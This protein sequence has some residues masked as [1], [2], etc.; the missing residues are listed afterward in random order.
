MCW[1]RNK[2]RQTDEGIK[3]K[4]SEGVD[5]KKK[6]GEREIEHKSSDES[7]K[8]AVRDKAEVW[9]SKEKRIREEEEI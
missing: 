6:D 7:R 5:E 1:G 8:G 3:R 9:E 4:K 2:E